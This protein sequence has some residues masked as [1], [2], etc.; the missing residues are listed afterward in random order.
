MIFL[1]IVMNRQP[2]CNMFLYAD[3]TKLCRYITSQEDNL[4]LQRTIDRFKNWS[5]TWLLELNISKCKWSHT[6]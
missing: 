4:S 2:C 5:D 6:A 1:T 3:D